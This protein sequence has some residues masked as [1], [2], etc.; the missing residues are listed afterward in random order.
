MHEI[1]ALEP[2]ETLGIECVFDMLQGEREIQ[3]IDVYGK[4]TI[5]GPG[6]VCCGVHAPLSVASRGRG[7]ARA[8][9]AMTMREKM[10]ALSCIVGEREGTKG[11][12]RFEGEE[13]L[14]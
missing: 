6:R 7:W 11:V 3:D 13:R 1:L 12:E 5:K 4:F 9:A 14:G 2:G 8:N 10:Q